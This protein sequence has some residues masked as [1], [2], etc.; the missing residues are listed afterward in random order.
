MIIKPVLKRL[1]D[2]WPKTRII[3][4]GDRTFL[5]AEINAIDAG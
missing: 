5:Q 4:R 1:R 3:L 2:A